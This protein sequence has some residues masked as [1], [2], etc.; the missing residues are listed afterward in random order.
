MDYSKGIKYM[1]DR[2]PTGLVF[3]TLLFI[4]LIVGVFLGIH[5]GITQ[6]RKEAINHGAAYWTVDKEGETKFNWKNSIE[7]ENTK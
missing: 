5:I 1:D 7:T 4:G 2:P 3:A 6:L